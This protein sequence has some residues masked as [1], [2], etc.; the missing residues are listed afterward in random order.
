MKPISTFRLDSPE[1]TTFPPELES[2]GSLRPVSIVIPFTERAL[3]A[4][5][6]E[7]AA[8]YAAK[9]PAEIRLIAVHTVP[10][11]LQFGCPVAVH[12]HL[13]EQLIELASHSRLPVQAQVILS[14]GRREGFEAAM[15][16]ESTVLIACRRR[17]WKTSEERLAAAFAARDHRVALFYVE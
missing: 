7:R 15:P 9:L 1:P 13:V 12:A 10:Y 14:R 11:P 6:V 17:P 4:A 8:A 3:A 2:S 5:A 16:P